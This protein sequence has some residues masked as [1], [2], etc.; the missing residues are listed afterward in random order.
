MKALN[1]FFFL[2]LIL[3]SEVF[4]PQTITGKITEAGTENFVSA[5]VIFKSSD[6]QNSEFLISKNGHYSLQL[7]KNYNQI[8]IEINALNYTSQSYTIENPEKNKTYNIDFQLK[9]E[10]IKEIKEIAIQS[11][12]K[13]FEVKKDTVNY[14][15]SSYSD[16]TEKKIEQILKKLPGIELNDNTGEIKYKGKAIETIKIDGDNLF[17][18]NYAVATK[19]INANIVDQI[20]A[21]ENYSENTLLKGIEAGDK[22]ALNIKLKKGKM[23]FSGDISYESGFAS[24]KTQKY[25][26]GLNIIQ[27]SNKYKAFGTF[28]YN[29][30][31]I[32]NTSFDYF[33]FS[34]NQD[35]MKDN[36]YIAK[37]NIPETIFTNFFNDGRAN[38]NNTIFNS[39]NNIF[40]ISKRV[41]LKLNL[42]QI[43]DKLSLIQNQYT[44]NFINN[45]SFTTT[46][47]YNIE[48]KPE[49][50]RIDTELKINTSK[51]SLLQ[52]N[53]KY[54]KENIFTNSE[55]ILNED[56][57][58]ITSLSSRS[59]FFKQNLNY[60]YKLS[61]HKAIQAELYHSENSIPQEF[62]SEPGINLSE[63]SYFNTQFSKFSKTIIG[64]KFILLGSSKKSDKKYHFAIGGEFTGTPLTSSVLM[65]NGQRNFV[66]NVDYHKTTLYT[67]SSYQWDFKGLKISPSYTIS[68]V[69]QDLK[70]P[71]QTLNKNNLFIEPELMI[72]YKLND[73][74]NLTSTTSYKQKAFSEENFFT[75]PIFI[76]NRTSIKNT[77]SLDVQKTFSAQI[78]YNILNLYKQY[79]FTI[80]A[81]YS[82]NNGN[83]FSKIF[84]TDI[85]TAY[86]YFYLPQKNENISFSMMIDKYI[87]FL[88]SKIK[89]KSYYS[90]FKY[91]NM[92][93]TSDLTDN[94]N[95]N[96][97]IEIAFKTAFPTKVNFEN[98]V[99]YNYISTQKKN[100]IKNTNINFRNNFKI[101]FKPSSDLLF[102]SSLD[103]INPNLKNGNKDNLFVDLM[104][105]KSLGNNLNIEFNLKN[106]LNNKTITR[107]LTTDYNIEYLNTN[108]IPRYFSAGIS[109]KF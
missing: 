51:L 24:D 72:S 47:F 80:G 87:P 105:N 102:L 30:I 3:F 74:S 81:L 94:I 84:V 90:I 91:K 57:R 50:Y 32:N 76:N 70:S 42:Y 61:D 101:L 54:Y 65:N 104:I 39:Y 71:E 86:N 2:F 45:S 83:Y 77:P 55:V 82:S 33:S 27:I 85:N 96:S 17:G 53:I 63:A 37:K 41:Q 60:T 73:I 99:S 29:N 22:V 109:Y 92:I 16:G 56:K 8:I 98:N 44:N 36:A 100:E 46:D 108:L 7:K 48:K 38:V 1:R 79:Q 23:D 69:K 18:S 97:N 28:G 25:N 93:N 40:K 64:G 103:Y 12:R 21:I 95:T 75:N 67:T 62:I 11:K 58:Y 31:G 59:S 89:I 26:I 20:Q 10:Q 4:F 9:K 78:F 19:N 6:N 49:L 14:N 106:L 34:Q 68:L 88:K 107:V 5:S 43:S 66:N 35:Q 52:Y 13:S 15:I